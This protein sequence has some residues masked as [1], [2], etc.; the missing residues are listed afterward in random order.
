MPGFRSFA[1]TYL[2]KG[3]MLEKPIRC[4]VCF[5]F[6][7][8]CCFAPAFAQNESHFIERTNF[9][10]I[11]W[12][13]LTVR[14]TGVGQLTEKRD[15][16][17][18]RITLTAAQADAKKNILQTIRR[19]RVDRKQTVFQI[20]EKNN[21]IEEEI[22]KLIQNARMVTQEYLSDGTAKIIM[23]LSLLGAFS[24]LVLPQELKQIES[25][26][27]IVP[28]ENIP[29]PF[30]GLIV[31]ATGIK[32]KP[33]LVPK[34][35]DES[36]KEIFGS[37]FASRESAVQQGMVRY[38]PDLEAARKQ[39]RVGNHPL[40]VK[41]LKTDDGEKTTIIISTA[42]AAKLKSASEHLQLLRKCLV[43]IA[44]DQSKP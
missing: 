30:T 6:I 26:R 22:L 41:G 38:V 44:A 24:Q 25:V 37:A 21:R 32:L 28:P 39:Q 16:N 43:I 31:D 5:W 12:S 42:D 8:I 35:M 17:A 10:V 36:H 19:L 11:N 3:V 15:E 9:G 2:L 14:A 34:I 40:V 7:L 29:A 4:I 33:A 1:G 18:P 27:S 13:Q 20:S 23:E